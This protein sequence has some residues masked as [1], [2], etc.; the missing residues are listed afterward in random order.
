M[1]EVILKQRDPPRPSTCA[2]IVSLLFMVCFI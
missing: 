1:I 2:A